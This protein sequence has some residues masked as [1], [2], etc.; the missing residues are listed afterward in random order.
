MTIIMEETMAITATMTSPKETIARWSA[1]HASER[2]TIQETGL[3]RRSK[4]TSPTRSRRGMLT[5]S[6]W[7]K[8]TMKLSLDITS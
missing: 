5:K 7:R 6:T 3:I 1:S 2:D 4:R 8:S